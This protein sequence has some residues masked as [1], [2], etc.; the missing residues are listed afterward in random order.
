MIVQSTSAYFHKPSRKGTKAK[1]P[2]QHVLMALSAFEKSLVSLNSRYDH[3]VFGDQDAL[4]RQEKG[5]LGTYLSMCSVCHAAPLFTSSEVA[6]IGA[7][8]QDGQAFDA[9]VGAITHDRGQYGAFKIPSIRNLTE[10][11]PY[12]H[13]GSLQTIEEVVEFYN[14]TPGHRLPDAGTREHSTA[15]VPGGDGF[16]P[17]RESRVDCLSQGLN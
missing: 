11:A 3:Y 12:M 9:G 16:N 13:S 14:N 6:V 4:T 1:F 10:T 15:W 17:I 8:N 2:I 5:G 7:P